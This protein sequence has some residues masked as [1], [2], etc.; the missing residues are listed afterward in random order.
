M[1]ITAQY[2]WILILSVFLTIFAWMLD[3]GWVT[4]R[5]GGAF[6]SIR[7]IAMVFLV[8]LL[9]WLAIMN[10]AATLTFLVVGIGVIVLVDLLFFRRKRKLNN[11]KQPLIVE[12]A[13]SFFFVLLFVWVVRSFIVQPYR[14]P[15]GSLQ[16]TV[17]PGDFLLVNQFA[18]GLRFPVTNAKMISTSEP[19]RG[20]LVLFYYPR[21][22][23]II[24]VKRLIGLPGDHI[25]YRDKVLYIN[26][27]EMPQKDIGTAI[28]D[29]PATNLTPEEHIPV[30]V[31]EEDLDGVKHQIFINENRPVWA[32]NFSVDVPPGHYFMVGDNRDNSGD[33]RAWGFVSEDMLIGKPFGIWMS[34]DSI[35]RKVR[36]DRIGHGV[37]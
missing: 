30:L 25:E 3:A 9:I 28:D 10:F 12:H 17:R 19:K 5:L 27:K 6:T 2:I 34:W 11:Y 31:K 33:S 22:P 32:G 29:E 37:K 35:N 23:S 26:G 1:I 4:K 7:N 13:R 16:P 24:F 8:V 18:Y 20:D 36:W 15:T 21:D 14:V